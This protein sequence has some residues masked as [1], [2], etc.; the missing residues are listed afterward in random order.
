MN[1]NNNSFCP[2][3]FQ[4]LATHPVGSVS[5]CCISD[6]TNAASHS[7]D[8]TPARFYNLANDR[9]IDIFNSENFRQARLS[10]LAGETPSSCTVCTNNE[11][12][13]VESKR[14]YERRIFPLFTV[15]QARNITDESGF[16]KEEDL[17]FEFIELRLGNVCNV[18]CRT[19]NPYSSS[20]WVAD[21]TKLAKVDMSF[22][23]FQHNASYRWPEIESFWTDLEKYIKTVKVIYING[24]EPTLIKQHIMFLDRLAAIVGPDVELRYNINATS[25]DEE[26][27]D[28]WNKFSTVNIQCSIDDLGIRNEYIRYPTNWD[29]VLR[30]IDRLQKEKFNL[31]ITQTVSFMNYSNIPKFYKFFNNKG[32]SIIHNLVYQPSWLSPDI[33][34]L[35]FRNSAH[36][37]FVE[38][39]PKHVADNLINSFN[40][41]QNVEGWGKAIVFTRSLDKIRNQVITDFL[42]EF[43]GLI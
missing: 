40:K 31:A 14:Q 41:E 30:I 39:L 8:F 23:A 26:I 7:R 6:H 22:P 37:R 38:L 17:N 5:F 29:T 19:C 2:L 33:L 12:N 32:I 36:A 35:E 34:P 21:Y 15:D 20:K 43:K 9:I 28:V 11:I 16:I 4:H 27:I 18:A 25:L 42:P 3:L 10:I 24:G 13:G 1:E